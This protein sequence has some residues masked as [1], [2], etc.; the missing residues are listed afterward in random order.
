MIDS[1]KISNL[2][3]V[4]P[5][6]TLDTVLPVV[7]NASGSNS[8]YKA[9]IS[10]IGNLVLFET[11]NLLLPASQS[12][13]A[14]SVTNAAQP[15]IT[16]VGTLSLSTLKISGGVNGYFLQTDGTGNL[17]WSAGPG[18][19]NGSPGGSNSQIQ[20]NSNGS[21]GG[22]SSLTFNVGTSTLNTVNIHAT[23]N[24]TANNLGNMSSLNIDGNSGHILDGK[25]VVAVSNAL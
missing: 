9:N 1:I 10:N 6:L 16:S 11:G 24:V 14:Q 25:G 15:N 2:P 18:A 19:S 22:N 5:N 12:I 17:N 23:G 7:S 4:G 3:A 8:T 13:L 21:F 20:Y